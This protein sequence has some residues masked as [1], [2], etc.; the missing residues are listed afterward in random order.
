MGLLDTQNVAHFL[1]LQQV[2]FHKASQGF[3]EEWQLKVFMKNGSSM[4]ADCGNGMSSPLPQ[5]HNT[6]LQGGF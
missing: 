1:T 5:F 4:M 6:V 2:Q 3:H